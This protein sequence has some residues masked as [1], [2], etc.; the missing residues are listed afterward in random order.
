MRDL[1]R[2]AKKKE[3]GKL[4]PHSKSSSTRMR[5]GFF[6]EVGKS[7]TLKRRRFSKNNS[8]VEIP[9]AK[10]ERLGIKVID[11]NKI[12]ALEPE[13]KEKIRPYMSQ[14]Q[15]S[16]KIRESSGTS[17]AIFLISFTIVCVF[18]IL[19]SNNINS[20]KDF[21]ENNSFINF[22]YTLLFCIFAVIVIYVSKFVYQLFIIFSKLI[23]ERFSRKDIIPDIINDLVTIIWLAE[24]NEEN[25]TET[26]N[27]KQQIFLLEKTAK[28]I[29]SELPRILRA[30]DIVTDAWVKQTMRHAAAAIREKKKSLLLPQ[31]STCNSHVKSIAFTLNY[32]VD[33][34]W[35]DLEKIEP[36]K[37][38]QLELR[39]FIIKS[40]VKLLRGVF[41]GAIPLVI[42]FVVQHTE[43]ALQGAIFT[44]TVTI[45]I[46]Y[47][48]SVF[49]SV[50]DPNFN[51]RVS[52]VK[53]I[54]D[55]LPFSGTGLKQ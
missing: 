5:K 25:L 19:Y 35:G 17:T 9:E 22:I 16:E 14:Y 3:S 38:T 10:V 36:A 40:V 32:I 18:L 49:T 20:L 51:D 52:N 37:L 15:P 26:E 28:S 12:K 31:K 45:L 54:N 55:L 7:S 50:L 39:Q 2:H 6:K 21:T 23:R 46:V 42:F 24:S 8:E 47:E 44:S 53:D 41:I 1:P 48:I 34:N 43:F 30:D 4:Q 27:R 33:G 11:L 29:E 13:L